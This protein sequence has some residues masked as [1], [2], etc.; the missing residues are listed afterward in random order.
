MAAQRPRT[1]A[2]WKAYIASL[3]ADELWDKALAANDTGF[4]RELVRD[5]YTPQEIEQVFVL[6]A[7]RFKALGRR[8]PLKGWYDLAAL[9]EQALP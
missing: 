1:T 2:Q 7:H 5:G 9:S 6:V 8:P 4:I 3:G